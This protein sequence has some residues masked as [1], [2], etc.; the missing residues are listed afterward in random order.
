MAR[1]TKEW[2]LNRYHKP[3]PGCG[4]WYWT[5]P[6]VFPV[7]VECR[8]SLPKG[9]AMWWWKSKRNARSLER[10]LDAYFEGGYEVDFDLRQS[11]EWKSQVKKWSEHWQDWSTQ[12][13]GG[14]DG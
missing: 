2:L 11:A 9:A 1:S 6:G 5:S 8:N 7:C 4:V 10:F 3:C 12:E 14:F 13:G